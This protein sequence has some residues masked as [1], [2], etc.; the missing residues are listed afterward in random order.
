MGISIPSGA[1]ITI[2]DEGSAVAGGDRVFNFTG[3]GVTS[4]QDGSNPN[5]V[6]VD[7]PGGGGAAED[8][9]WLITQ[10]FGS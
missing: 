7:I 2:L 6:N 1:P 8:Q 10:F 9:V 5:Q 4:T 3:A